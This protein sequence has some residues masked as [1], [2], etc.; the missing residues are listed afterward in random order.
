[1]INAT[2]AFL[3]IRSVPQA[4]PSSPRERLRNCGL[5]VLP[6]LD[7]G[8]V[9]DPQ[10][11]HLGWLRHLRVAPLYAPRPPQHL[12]VSLRL[13][14]G[15]QPRMQV[16]HRRLEV[17]PPTGQDG[18]VLG[19]P[20]AAPHTGAVSRSRRRLLAPG[21][22][23]C[24]PRTPGLPRSPRPA[25]GTRGLP[26]PGASG[27]PCRGPL[28]WRLAPALHRDPV[29]AALAQPHDVLRSGPPGV[30]DHLR[31]R[32][33]RLAGPHRHPQLARGVGESASLGP[34]AGEHLNA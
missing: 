10:H 7:P 6:R 19:L 32:R 28:W 5:R 24:R 9:L 30:Y 1:M 26:E 18:I 22:P 20:R 4:L 21:S 25:A 11:P 31:P 14:L 17:R 27:K 34:I 13:A 2:P 33:V 16:A 8:P 15:A 3:T 12:L 23:L 29:V